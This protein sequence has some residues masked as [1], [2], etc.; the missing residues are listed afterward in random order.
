MNEY[1]SEDYEPYIEKAK[2]YQSQWLK[3]VEKSKYIE[4]YIKPMNNQTPKED[5]YPSV[6]TPDDG[7]EDLP[8]T[9]PSIVDPIPIRV[10]RGILPNGTK[11]F[12]GKAVWNQKDGI[13]EFWVDDN[14]LM[15]LYLDGARRDNSALQ[16]TK[17][18]NLIHRFYNQ[19]PPIYPP[20]QNRVF[21]HALGMIP[22]LPPIPNQ[23]VADCIGR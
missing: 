2:E 6:P 20:T 8:K 17:E 21:S 15:P 9:N 4:N 3:E 11:F 14:E 13:H 12:V 22:P 16:F 23:K 5:V 7:F 18:N 1:E 19:N 10:N